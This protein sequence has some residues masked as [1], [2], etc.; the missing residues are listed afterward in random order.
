[1][2]LLAT[3]GAYTSL[4]KIFTE[5]LFSC[6]SKAYSNALVLLGSFLF[7]LFNS[8]SLLVNKHVCTHFF[9]MQTYEIGKWYIIY[10]KI[11]KEHY[12]KQFPVLLY[13][14][15]LSQ[16]NWFT[17]NLVSFSEET[18]SISCLI[19]RILYFKLGFC[20]GVILHFE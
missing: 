1:M 20:S 3:S 13:N 14:P 16:L 5:V 7:N 11:C 9:V 15:L 19:F 8:D 17:L 12:N 4:S 10:L 2:Y 6:R 18:A